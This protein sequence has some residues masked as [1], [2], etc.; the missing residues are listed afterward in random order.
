MDDI[1]GWLK[2]VGLGRAGCEVLTAFCS[3]VKDYKDTGVEFFYLDK[4][5]EIESIKKTESLIVENTYSVE[6]VD[7]SQLVAPTK[8]RGGTI[9]VEGNNCFT[10]ALVFLPFEFE[11]EEK[12]KQALEALGQV[13]KA[14]D[15]TI[16]VDCRKIP[17]T[18]G[19][20]K[21]YIFYKATEL[22]SRILKSIILPAVPGLS[23]MRVDLAEFVSNF[24]HSTVKQ[25]CVGV[26]KPAE[27]GI[28]AIESALNNPVCDAGIDIYISKTCFLSFLLLPLWKYERRKV[29]L[30]PFRFYPF[31]KV[32]GSVL[33]KNN[34][35]VNRFKP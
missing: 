1:K 17:C 30:P 3:E 25:I 8:Y 9:F 24:K 20:S 4:P 14:V 11:G 10:L 31:Y 15:F 2:V 29:W 28:E 21:E 7:M 12:R 27:N 6:D 19:T 18:E 23:I 34:Y 33:I 13:R 22:M 16:V 5:S 35:I 32:F 26:G